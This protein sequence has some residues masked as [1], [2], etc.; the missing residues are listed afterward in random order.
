MGGGIFIEWNNFDK[1]TL[2]AFTQ[3][4]Q[5]RKKL[6]A[7]IEDNKETVFRKQNSWLTKE[8]CSHLPEK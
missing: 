5:I 6:P 1:M 3:L 8:F 2:L 4:S 7:I